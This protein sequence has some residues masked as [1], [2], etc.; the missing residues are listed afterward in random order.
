M[1]ETVTISTK[2][3]ND[4]IP[5]VLQKL[6]AVGYPAIKE[7]LLLES[8]SAIE[9]QLTI[10]VTQN[11]ETDKIEGIIKEQLM[12]ITTVNRV[13]EAQY[14]RF[15]LTY[16]SDIIKGRE[17]ADFFEHY[18]KDYFVINDRVESFKTSPKVQNHT[19]SLKKTVSLCSFF[20]I[21][22]MF[23]PFTGEW[24]DEMITIP[25]QLKILSFAVI[26]NLIISAYVFNKYTRPI[27]LRAFKNYRDFRS[28]DM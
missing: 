3:Q 12:G 13:H 21:F 6:E 7:P 26:L 27:V 20:L 4:L 15:R 25:K 24:Y 22:N 2:N 19:N 17:I 5:S 10:K 8:G 14:L 18:D 1:Q 16:D 9:R 11:N 28:M 23:L